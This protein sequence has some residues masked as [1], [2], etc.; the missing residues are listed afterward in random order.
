MSDTIRITLT[1]T[2]DTA[3]SLLGIVDHAIAEGDRKVADGE[4]FS[5][6]AEEFHVCT[7][8]ALERQ[9]LGPI[10]KC[11]PPHVK[12]PE[13][14]VGWKVRVLDDGAPSDGEVM[15]K[16]PDNTAHVIVRQGITEWSVHW[17][18]CRVEM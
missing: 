5:K 4:E 6:D 11:F 16:D 7:K 14:L 17:G 12:G 15:R 13:D 18:L 10:R 2:P 1:M 9:V 8:D 3:R